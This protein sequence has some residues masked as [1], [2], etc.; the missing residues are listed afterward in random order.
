MS[1]DRR[2]DQILDATRTIVDAEGFAAVTIARVAEAAGI[3]RTLVYHQFA[4]LSG[5][6]TALVDR[7]AERAMAGL[8]KVITERPPADRDPFTAAL[9]GLINAADADPATWRMF[10]MPSEGGPPE[11]YERIAQGRALGRRRI[12]E[13]LNA[14]DQ[15][16]PTG[17]D[18]A[19][20]IHL[21][22]L[23]GD[24]LLRLH[25]R[26]PDAY[27]ADRVLTQCA[28]MAAQMSQPHSTADG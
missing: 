20:S 13:L 15:L 16:I 9:E 1:A 26:D 2:R 5:L 19:L 28:R 11:L 18:P 8:L 6:L 14:P 27:P 25:L 12:I 23:V 7:E 3:T 24:E 17:P 4:D 10:L 21:L 22:H